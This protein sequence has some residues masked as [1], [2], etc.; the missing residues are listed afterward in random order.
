MIC[1]TRESVAEK[2]ADAGFNYMTQ[3]L[4]SD[5][6]VYTFVETDELRKE[7]NNKRNYTKKDWF[8]SPGNKLMF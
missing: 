4:N 8:Y 7:L 2:L 1:V 6:L 3:Y 5:Q